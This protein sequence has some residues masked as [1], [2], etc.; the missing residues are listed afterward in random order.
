MQPRKIA[1]DRS[2]IIFSPKGRLFQVEYARAA[3]KKGT[4]IVGLK[5][6]DGVS[7]I[8]EKRTSSRLI[9]SRSLD[10]IFQIDKHIGCA[11]C[12][13]LGDARILV[14]RARLYAQFNK[15]RYN[16]KI[17]IRTLVKQICD[18]KQTYTQYAVVRP[19]GMTI[20]MGGVDETGP[21]LFATDP[22]GAFMEYKARSEGA[23]Q[24]EA[25]AFFE[26]KYNKHLS[27]DKAILLGIQ[28]L[29]KSAKGTFNPENIEIAMVSKK[30]NFYKLTHKESKEYVHK[31][32]K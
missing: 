10:K 30:K 16:G 9:V 26:H 12:G 6:E 20:L 5:F 19:F 28:A 22:S 31:A 7:L 24:K 17:P 13:L 18:F 8:V 14:D 29:H 2:N 27:K 23:G 15:I 21:H 4:T 32:I 3:V 25:L 1:Y 11:I